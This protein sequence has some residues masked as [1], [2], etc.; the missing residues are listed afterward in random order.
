M[1]DAGALARIVE[2]G[3]A[4]VDVL[5][6]AA[7]PQHPVGGVFER[8]LNEALGDAEPPGDLLGETPGVVGVERTLRGFG[9]D[10]LDV[11]P[12][13]LAVAPPV[14]CEGPARQAFAR[15]PFALAV[16]QQA[17]RRVTV[18]QLA[19]QLVGKLALGRPERVGVPLR[20]L[21]IVDRH[22]GR[23]AAHGEPHILRR[24]VG[25]DL[26]AERVERRP[27]LVGKRIGDARLLGD[28]RDV[29]LERE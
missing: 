29:H 15:I 1:H 26:L 10:Q 6:Q 20:R 27:G 16:M 18:A 19:D 2:L 7:F 11:V 17:A 24:E 13:R 25:I 28:A 9:R 5:R 3:I 14:E 12:D 21:V 23:L 4:R 8:R 22:E